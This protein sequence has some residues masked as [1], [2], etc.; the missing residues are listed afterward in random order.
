[1]NVVKKLC[2]PL[3]FF[4]KSK[5]NTW[6]PFRIH[7]LKEY[8]GFYHFLVVMINTV[9]SQQ[10]GLTVRILSSPDQ[11][12]DLELK[13]SNKNVI[14]HF[15]VF[16]TFYSHYWIK[17]RGTSEKMCILHHRKLGTPCLDTNINQCPVMKLLSFCCYFVCF[18]FLYW[19]KMS[20]ENKKVLVDILKV[21]KQNLV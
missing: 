11:N 6:F 3:S 16:C 20:D 4:F 8:K 13:F 5:K 18:C 9:V 19:R 2:S 10:S 7:Y 12:Q 17:N 14:A 21:Y 15:G 1:M